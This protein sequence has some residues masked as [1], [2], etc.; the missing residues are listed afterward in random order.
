MKNY[1]QPG[2]AIRLIAPAGGVVSGRPYA[3]GGITGIA[4]ET[5]IEGGSFELAR[6]GVYAVEKDASEFAPGDAVY[7]LN[8]AATS[9]AGGKFLGYAISAAETG[10]ETVDVLLVTGKAGGAAYTEISFT[11]YQT[12]TAAPVIASQ[13]SSP[14][15]SITP[16][17]EEPGLFYFT[18]P[19]DTFTGSAKTEILSTEFCLTG[20]TRFIY[21]Y[22]TGDQVYVNAL[23]TSFVG[24]NGVAGDPETESPPATTVIRIFPA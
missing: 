16:G 7:A 4:T 9:D 2:N 6:E 11:W 23:D 17:Y 14:A 13:N 8:R 3:I 12:G 1:V 18:F 22:I 19:A 24:A 20:A 10:D 15:V 5:E 21:A